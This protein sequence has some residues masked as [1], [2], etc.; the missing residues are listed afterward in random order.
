MPVS[1][2]SVLR[3]WL[4]ASRPPAEAPMPTMGN[5]ILSDGSGGPSAGGDFGAT[6]SRK[7]FGGRVGDNF[8]RRFFRFVGLG[9][10]G[11]PKRNEDAA[12][13]R[14]ADHLDP[15]AESELFQGVGP[16]CF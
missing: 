8:L 7:R 5:V 3:S 12:P 13:Q 4:K 16:V 11:A 10:C 15:V 14:I 6:T 2:A 1:A 9:S